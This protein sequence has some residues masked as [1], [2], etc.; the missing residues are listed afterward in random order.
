MLERA[1]TECILYM[2]EYQ[3]FI[4]LNST[5][6][7]YGHYELL[8]YINNTQQITSLHHIL[9]VFDQMKGHFPARRRCSV[10]KLTFESEL[11][12]QCE[13][14]E[15]FTFYF[16]GFSSKQSFVFTQSQW[17]DGDHSIRCGLLLQPHPPSHN[18]SRLTEL[19]HKDLN[20][21]L[22]L[23]NFSRMKSQR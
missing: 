12:L 6:F 9:H 2:R 21:C 7:C 16:S 13:N 18:L 22:V 3:V 15:N 5:T 17:A 19:T 1:D 4:L 11:N 10:N 8:C 14:G 20:T 23:W